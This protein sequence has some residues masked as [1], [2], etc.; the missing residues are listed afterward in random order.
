M[1]SRLTA[2]GLDPVTATT[3]G[4]YVA[5]K[6]GARFRDWYRLVAGAN[7]TLTFDDTAHELTIDVV[8]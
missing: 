6:S 3:D 4:A 8:V 7:V 5:H 1:T 2:D